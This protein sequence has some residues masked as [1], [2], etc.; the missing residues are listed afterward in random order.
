[1]QFYGIYSLM[2]DHCI[3]DYPEESCSADIQ[4][5]N[6]EISYCMTLPTNQIRNQL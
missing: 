5:A 1:M 6:D 4:V 3:C 2:F